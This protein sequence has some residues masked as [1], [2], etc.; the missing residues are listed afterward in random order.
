MFVILS[1]DGLTM[2]IVGILVTKETIAVL[3]IIVSDSFKL[4]SLQ[5]TIALQYL[6]CDF[7]LLYTVLT[8]HHELVTTD[9]HILI[10]R[11]IEG[12]VQADALI[13]PEHLGIEATLAATDDKVRFLSLTQLL[14]HLKAIAELLLKHLQ[15]PVTQAYITFAEGNEGGSD[16][17]QLI[18]QL[19]KGVDKVVDQTVRG[20]LRP[21]TK[22][23][24]HLRIYGTFKLVLRSILE[25]LNDIGTSHET[26][27][28]DHT[29]IIPL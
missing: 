18:N 20:I 16:N 15:E 23:A 6:R 3:S 24:L 14:Q 2:T 27:I 9:L 12:R 28:N 25:D 29:A 17:Q 5:P 21:L 13:A 19:I 11:H 7:I 10:S 26:V 22:A 1:E 4:T 8:V